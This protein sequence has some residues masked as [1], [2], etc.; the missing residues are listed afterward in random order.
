MGVQN[1]RSG[2]EIACGDQ[3]R[4]SAARCTSLCTSLVQYSFSVAVLA[5]QLLCALNTI[6]YDAVST[7][8]R[9]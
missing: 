4:Y 8:R 6:A 2:G 7:R 3:G 5:V 9:R 1:G